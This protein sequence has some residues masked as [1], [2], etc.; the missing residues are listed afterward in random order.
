MNSKA[1]VAIQTLHGVFVQSLF[2]GDG[3]RAFRLFANR[4]DISLELP[5]DGISLH[6][7]GEV[8]S[9]LTGGHWPDEQTWVISHTP[10]I[11]VDADGRSARGSWY[12]TVFWLEADDRNT[13]LVRGSA[14]FDA[15]LVLTE[16][17]WK[18]LEVQF[19]YM[20]TLEPEPYS[21]GVQPAD[22]H[23]KVFP[24]ADVVPPEPMDFVA[25][26]N[27]MGRWSVDRRKGGIDLFSQRE[28]CALVLPT[29]LEEPCTGRAAVEAGLRKLADMQARSE[30]WALTIPMLTTPVISVTGDYAEG[31][32]LTL[33][34]DCKGPAFGY[35][36]ENS[37]ATAAL[38]SLKVS[39]WRENG[40]WKLY[41]CEFRP[42]LTLPHLRLLES[43]FDNT[44][45]RSGWRDAPAHVPVRDE[46]AAADILKLEEYVAFWV[47]GL[48]YR[49]EAPFY[50]SRLAIERPE[51]LEHGTGVTKMAHGLEDVTRE[52]FAMV[53]KF[54]T[55]QPKAP[56]NHIGTT[57]VIELSEDGERAEAVWL[58]YGWTTV[59]E[60]FG[61]NEPPYK[62]N[63][64]IAR[65]HFKFIRLDGVWK[66]YSF[67]WAPF[68]RGGMWEFDYAKTKG[69]SGTTSCRR[70]PLPLER[71]IYEHDP[72]RKGEK[73][74]LE[75]SCVLCPYER[76][77]TGELDAI[78]SQK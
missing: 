48:R 5:D 19:Y 13:A 59:A 52:I 44:L 45:M 27:L 72:A 7:P 77:W 22:G 39:F 54:V 33:T 38:G 8:K 67:N 65:Y 43:S 31:V 23:E 53:N 25:L 12:A 64:A 14:R 20:M 73:V 10:A 55:F 47:S 35:G 56:G 11:R 4:P 69:W 26:S 24:P 60:V 58:D 75:P 18:Y 34:H 68:F 17:G 62:A 57:P 51:L 49:S 70:F 66:V 78:P 63:P 16:D 76:E 32:W 37:Y 1:N 46:A 6:G 71:Y 3:A 41:R 21:G 9:Y 36:R 28:D 29:L 42:H 30:P 2:F 50:Y 61:I 40:E 15:D 74:I